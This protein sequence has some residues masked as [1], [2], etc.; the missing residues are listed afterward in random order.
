MFFIDVQGTLIEDNTKL[1]TRG[2][3]EFI[4]YLNAHSIPYMVITNS[5]KNPSDEF[6]GYLNSIG[7][8]IPKERYLDP[9]MMLERHIGKNKKVAA[10][11]SEPFLRVVE[12][13]GYLLD[14]SKPDVVLIAIKEDFTP[15]EYAQMIEFLLGGAELIGMHETTLY[16]KNHKRYPGVGAI[17]KMLEFATS[18]PYTVVGKPSRAFFDEALRK[19]ALQKEGAAYPDITIISDD[20][21]GDLIGAQALGMRGILLLSG[22]IRS[23]DEILPSLKA[24]ERPVAIYADMQEVLE[25]L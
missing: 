22:K 11:G 3:V 19:I 24:H 6:L 1:P 8:A 21:K 4:G 18:A 23:A 20:M 17:L 25:R 16:V 12:S 15:D 7:L 14:Y 9:L 5:T 2:A 13:M 10:Y